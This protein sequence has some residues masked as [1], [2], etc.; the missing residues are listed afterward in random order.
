ME[1][2][3][4]GLFFVLKDVG[5]K[6]KKVLLRRMIRNINNY[7]TT[8][9]RKNENVSTSTVQMPLMLMD[10]MVYYKITIKLK[11]HIHYM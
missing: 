3:A 1:G 2:I 8:C 9:L 7:S 6:V 4:V 11:K 10:N 5:M